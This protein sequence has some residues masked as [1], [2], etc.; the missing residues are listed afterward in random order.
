MVQLR[1]FQLFGLAGKDAMKSLTSRLKSALTV[2][3]VVA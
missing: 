3:V 2:G 1:K